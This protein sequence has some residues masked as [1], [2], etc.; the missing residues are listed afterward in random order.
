MECALNA[1]QQIF[2]RIMIWKKILS[3]QHG[4]ISDVNCEACHGPGS[5]HLDW[6]KLPEGARDY[7][8]NMGLV[9]KTSGT[10]SKQ[11]IEACAPCHSRRT[12][13]GPNES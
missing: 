8:G 1:I 2:K 9:L 7:D 10:T 11:Y 13:F 6:A 5:E 4:L 3:I 12:S